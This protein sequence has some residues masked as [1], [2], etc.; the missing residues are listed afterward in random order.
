M[1]V[2]EV[3]SGVVCICFF[4]MN[5]FGIDIGGLVVK[6]V[7]VD[8]MMGKLFGEW[9]CIVML[10]K[11]LLKELVKIVVEIVV[12]FVWKGLIGFGFFGVI[13]GMMVM[14]LVNLYK[15]FIG[16]NLVKL[17]LKVI[18]VCVS[19]VNDVDVVGI[20]EMWFGVGWK[21]KG[22]VVLFMFGMGVG[23]VLFYCGLLYLNFEFGYLLIKGDLVEKYVVVLV[24]EKEDFLWYKWGKWLSY[25]F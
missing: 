19:V 4:Y 7:L 10:K 2:G 14:M 21:E 5:V 18:G 11:V 1:F 22:M 15:D 20:V 6:G 12:Y 13:Y 3:S 16:C 24:K 25:Y 8:I 23:L 9:Y 17:V